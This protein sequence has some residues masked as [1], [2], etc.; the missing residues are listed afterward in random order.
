MGKMG[1]KM[2]SLNRLVLSLVLL[3][4][5]FCSF[6]GAQNLTNVTA[7]GPR[8]EW[9]PVLQW[10][11]KSSRAQGEGWNGRAVFDHVHSRWGLCSGANGAGLSDSRSDVSFFFRFRF[12]GAVRSRSVRRMHQSKNGSKGPRGSVMWAFIPLSIVPHKQRLC[13]RADSV[14]W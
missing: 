9:D 11:G 13:H 3:V 12:G 14:A 6:V 4:L 7:T 10:D 5:T 2:S 1:E 8:S